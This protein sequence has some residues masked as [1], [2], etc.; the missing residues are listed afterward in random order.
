M[1]ALK[2]SENKSQKEVCHINSVTSQLAAL[3]FSVRVRFITEKV[4]IT[5]KKCIGL[6]II[7]STTSPCTCL[8][9][10]FIDGQARIFVWTR[11]PVEISYGN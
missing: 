3:S 7:C 1:S 9:A 4:K 8:I 2:I 6:I 5:M 10:V 11:R